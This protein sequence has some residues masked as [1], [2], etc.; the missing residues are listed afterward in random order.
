MKVFF[1]FVML[2]VVGALG[3]GIF[4]LD[5]VNG[6][7]P[8]SAQTSILFERGK[9]FEA[10]SDELAQQ[11]VIEHPLWF[12]AIAV[13]LG[14]ARKFKAG[15]YQFPASITPHAVM[16][17]MAQGKVVQHKLTVAEGLNVREV[18]KLVQDEPALEGDLPAPVKEGSLLPETY[19]FTRGM[20]RTELVAL[21][22][23]AMTNT[24]KA[25]W[26]KRTSGL[27]YDTAQKALIMA[28]IVEKET[29][30]PQE[31]P[32]IASVFVNRL[33]KN[34]RL[35][36]DPTVVYGVEQADNAPMARSLTLNDL[37][38]PTPYNTYTIDGLPPG[39]ICNP[40]KA[41]IEAAVNP[42]QSDDLYFVA[43]GS[44]GH[45]FAQTLEQH[46]RNVVAYRAKMAG[47]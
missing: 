47:R 20:K 2:C 38:T 31:R 6:P 26:D 17:M 45:R 30:L 1:Y 29:G 40:G 36:T 32:H 37:H 13:A 14:D 22:Q 46:N 9:G 35:Q 23:K 42:A 41:S 5:Y 24:L 12:K 7:G 33:R 15:E 39:P 16:A 25:A 11:G 21:M 43:T 18:L 3:V 34:I 19:L 28:S 27:P 44:G 8:S 10:M 4:A